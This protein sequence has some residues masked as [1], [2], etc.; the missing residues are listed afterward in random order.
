MESTKFD[1]IFLNVY[2][3]QYK[4]RLAYHFWNVV[5]IAN[6]GKKSK[7]NLPQ[8]QMFDGKKEKRGRQMEGKTKEEA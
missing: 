8:I 4:F 5:F 7:E 2:R 1:S 6:T 3:Y